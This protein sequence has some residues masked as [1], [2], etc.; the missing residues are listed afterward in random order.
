MISFEIIIFIESSIIELKHKKLFHIQNSFDKIFGNRTLHYFVAKN[1]FPLYSGK[2]STC[3]RQNLTFFYLL[4]VPRAF[5]S[6]DHSIKHFD[7][8]LFQ[9]IVFIS[10][11]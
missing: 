3:T 9:I 11:V 8:F 7:V 1:V 10:A 5:D 2:G 4:N 6:G